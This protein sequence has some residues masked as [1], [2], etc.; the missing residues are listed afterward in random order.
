MS[1]SSSLGRSWLHMHDVA[2]SLS[3]ARRVH[4]FSRF[5][6]SWYYFYYGFS[7]GSWVSHIP[8]IQEKVGISNGTLGLFLVCGGISALLGIALA[9][10]LNRSVGSAKSALS[11]AFMTLLLPLVGSAWLPNIGQTQAR[12]LLMLG[13]LGLG[14]I[15]SMVD[16]SNSSHAICLE[17][18]LGQSIVGSMQGMNSFGNLMGVLVG[19]TCCACGVNPFVYFCCLVCCG[20]IISYVASTFLIG[21][22]ESIPLNP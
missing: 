15:C 7:F 21:E 19:G 11:G 2:R 22:P 17:K 14:V 10:H 6:L 12:V 5:A 9:M 18:L 20:V 1:A 3:P 4:D 16:L 8:T 13:V